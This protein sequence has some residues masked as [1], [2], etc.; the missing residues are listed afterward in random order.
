VYCGGIS[1]TAALASNIT[2]NPGTYVLRDATG[3]LGIKTGGLSITLTAL[4]TIT[5]NGVTFYN[6]GPTTGFSITE[7]IAG[8]SIVSL[9]NVNLTAPSSGDYSG[10]LFFQQRGVTAPA[11]FLANL[12]EGSNMQGTI[13]VPDGIVNYGV[14]A[15]SS[16]YNGLVAKDINFLASVASVFGDDYSSLAGGSPLR[17]NNVQLVQ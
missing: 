2:F 1:I 11:T 8:G 16:S 13:Y 10:I 4:S 17:G 12:V 6:E 7:P 15:L 5:G 9:N 14:S 3:L